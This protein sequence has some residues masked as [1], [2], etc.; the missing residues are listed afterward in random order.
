M[1]FSWSWLAI[2]LSRSNDDSFGGPD[3]EYRVFAEVGGRW[4]FLNE[5]PP[6]QHILS[7]GIG[8]TGDETFDIFHE[9]FVFIPPSENFRVHASGWEADGADRIF[10]QLTDPNSR[11]EAARFFYNNY[12]FTFSNALWGGKDDQIGEIND[13]WGP[14]NGYGLGPRHE[15]SSA[16]ALF[17]DDIADTDPNDS[18]RLYYTIDELPWPYLS[19]SFIAPPGP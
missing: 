12:V 8:D 7:D 9:F 17:T 13:V 19:I 14:L 6:V 5:K 18:Y 10:G 11:C 3:G 4:L 16:G 1:H 15:S 2:L